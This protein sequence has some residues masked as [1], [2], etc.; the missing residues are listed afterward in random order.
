VIAGGHEQS[1]ARAEGVAER[2]YMLDFPGVVEDD[3]ADP[4]GE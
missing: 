2:G 3:E 1:A 4:A